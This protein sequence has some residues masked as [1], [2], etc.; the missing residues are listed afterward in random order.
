VRCSDRLCGLLVMYAGLFVV[1]LTGKDVGRSVQ[2]NLWF[3]CSDKN[4]DF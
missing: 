1:S 3:E 4:V 2:T